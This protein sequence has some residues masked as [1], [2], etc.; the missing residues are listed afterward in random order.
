MP[1]TYTHTTRA[2]FEQIIALRL[3]ET[4]SQPFVKFA[5]DEVDVALTEALRTWSALTGMWQD[6]QAALVTAGTQF[7]D[8]P[9]L[10]PGMRGYTVLDQELVGSIQYSLLE[11][12]SP[13]IWTGSAQFS[14]ALV[15]QALQRR[16]D[17][18]L[19]DTGCVITRH[20]PIPN[21]PGVI[22]PAA[23]GA[24]AIDQQIIDIRRAAW[25]DGT[26]TS[27]LWAT[28]NW[29]LRGRSATWNLEPGVPQT[30]AFNQYA[31]AILQLAP[32]NA[33]GGT[34]DLLT[35]D[36][37]ATLDP[38]SGV[39]MGVPDDFTPFVRWGALADLLSADGPGRDFAR[40]G[41]CES[42][43]QLGVQAAKSA[44][45]IVDARF[46]GKPA[47]FGSVTSLDMA[48]PMR[49]WQNRPGIP[50]V[51]AVAGL[52]LVAVAPPPAAN[53][54][55]EA[56]LVTNAPI[57]A[58]PGFFIQVP[59]ELLDLL[60][61]FVEHLLMF[62]IAGREWAAT[63]DGAQAFFAAAQAR[64]QRLKAISVFEDDERVFS[65]AQERAKPRRD[66]LP[67]KPGQGG[68]G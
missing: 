37:G 67:A 53:T 21:A 2:Q 4:A 6:T 43:Y 62:K 3:A 34:L 56:T 16:R 38:A 20:S 26:R 65:G 13:T 46:N 44:V 1:N 54:S 48:P 29:A 61:G 41:H 9:T 40:A 57:P 31:P 28:S 55:L 15:A 47:Q 11:P 18:F 5:A 64:N 10:F 50:Q 30:Y 63:Q 68:Q 24:A 8:L 14:M 27:P 23:E 66:E 45:V 32:P 7:V 52:N 35:V 39:L 42:M 60:V 12:K 33:V 17:Q 25:S 51:M 36:T 49:Y 22:D 59:R 19:L 58:A